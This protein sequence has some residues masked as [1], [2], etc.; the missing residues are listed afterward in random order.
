MNPQP[1]FADTAQ[2]PQSP[3]A[4]AGPPASPPAVKV[5]VAARSHT[6]LVRTNNEDVYLVI[7]YGRFW[8]TLMTNLPPGDAPERVGH[9]GY[10]FLVADGVGG[11]AA[12]EVASRLAVKTLIQLAL[13]TPDWILLPPGDGEWRRVQERAREYYQQIDATI[14]AEADERPELA[15]MGTTMTIARNIGSDLIVVHVGDSR[16]YRLRGE[17][18]RQL[19]RDH[20]LAQ[21]LADARGISPG[22]VVKHLFRHVLTRALGGKLRWGGADV[23]KHGLT[24]GDQILIC[25]D[26]LT[27]MVPTAAIVGVLRTAPTADAACQELVDLALKNGGKDNV[28]VVVARY[29]IAAGVA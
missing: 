20:T 1:P 4:Q 28:T 22:D 5:D 13:E 19:T 17:E 14:R 9:E 29:Q 21:E 26:G 3:V 27:E 23:E 15:G 18:L 25:S 24:D 16:A 10:G 7:K 6:G 8:Q 2:Y 12:G 11:H